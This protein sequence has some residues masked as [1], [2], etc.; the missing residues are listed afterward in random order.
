MTGGTPALKQAMA[1]FREFV[2]SYET[3]VVSLLH[4]DNVIYACHNNGVLADIFI[5]DSPD[6]YDAIEF[7]NELSGIKR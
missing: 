3:G 4:V 1:A 5:L 7:L 6:E 2:D